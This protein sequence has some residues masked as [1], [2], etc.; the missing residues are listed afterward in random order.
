MIL[1]S[2]L[3]ELLDGTADAA[4]AADLQGEIRTWNKAA[5][6]L[7][8]YPASI[9]I[10]KPC[11]EI[12]GGTVSTGIRVCCE[13][14]DVLDCV[15]AGKEVSNFDMEISTRSGKRVSVNVSLLVASNERTERRLAIHFLRDISEKKKSEQLTKKILSIAKALVN[16][17]GEASNMP[18]ITPLTPQESNILHLLKSGKAT[19]EITAELKISMATLRNHIYNLNQKLHTTSRI[20]AVIQAQKR[21][22]I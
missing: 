14:C 2:Q 4:F 1:E 11:S 12:V 10:G 6:R 13:S 22:L 20:E 9:A 19:K 21:G 18:P 17:N 5:E 7:F 8:G 16:G 15:R 3:A